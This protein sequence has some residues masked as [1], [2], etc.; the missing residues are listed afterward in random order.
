M[1]GVQHT[2]QGGLDGRGSL[3]VQR[4]STSLAVTMCMFRF[5]MAAAQGRE[6]VGM[7]WGLVARQESVE[8]CLLVSWWVWVG[9]CV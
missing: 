2:W 6:K 5:Q 1:K 3:G 4:Q 7:P 8:M 9:A